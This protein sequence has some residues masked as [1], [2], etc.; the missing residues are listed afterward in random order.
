MKIMIIMNMQI[1]SLS[2]FQLLQFFYSLK[3][4]VKLRMEFNHNVKN[5]TQKLKDMHIS[6]VST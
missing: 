4:S 5:K 3:A 6:I 2:V 1:K